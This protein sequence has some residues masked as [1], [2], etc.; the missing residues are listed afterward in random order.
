MK[1]CNTY[2]EVQKEKGSNVQVIYDD[3]RLP[4]ETEIKF[5]VDFQKESFKTNDGTKKRPIQPVLQGAKYYTMDRNKSTVETKVSNAG[6][7]TFVRCVRDLTPREVE[8][9]DKQMK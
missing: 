2:R 8:E 3:W 9:L 5:I 6:S 7:G 1:H 4:T